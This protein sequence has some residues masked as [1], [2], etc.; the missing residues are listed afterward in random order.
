[1][2]TNAVVVSMSL[3]AT[4]VIALQQLFNATESLT[5]QTGQTKTVALILRVQITN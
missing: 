1:M 5:A 4:M 3:R 2:N